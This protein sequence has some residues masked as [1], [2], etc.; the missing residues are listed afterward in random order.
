MAPALLRSLE[1]Q[2]EGGDTT[3]ALTTARRYV[4]MGH[5]PRSLAGILGDAASQRDPRGG[6]L[7]ALP[8]VAAAAEEYLT[9]PGAGW[10]GF[11]SQSAA[12]S[13]LLTAAVRLAAELPGDTALATRVRDAI[14]R[15]VA[16]A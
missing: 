16:S 1:H 7:H 13:P 6:G 5:P 9:Q 15:H 2:L 3:G 14:A 11:S 4:S 12:Q 8:L 10:L